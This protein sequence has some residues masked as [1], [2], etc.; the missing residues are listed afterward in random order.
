MKIDMTEDKI[1]YKLILFCNITYIVYFLYYRIGGV[2][3][4]VLVCG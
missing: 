4:S 2:I 3:V 1:V